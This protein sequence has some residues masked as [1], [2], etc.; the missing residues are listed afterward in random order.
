MPEIWP[1]SAQ[2][3]GEVRVQV[4]RAARRAGAAETT[5]SDIELA[6]SEAV[7][8]AVLHAYASPG[9]RGDTVKVTTARRDGHF[10]VWVA[11]DGRGARAPGPTP[12]MGWGLRLMA[13]LTESV[14]IGV[15][16]DGRTQ[17]EMCFLLPPAPC[18]TNGATTGAR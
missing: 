12:G 1:A 2:S 9:V 10:H 13:G 5:V 8:N 14:H 18:D 16:D 7:T 4:A 6:V 3:I 17:V 15:L 11:D